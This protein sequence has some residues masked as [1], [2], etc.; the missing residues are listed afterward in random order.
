MNFWWKKLKYWVS[1]PF[2]ARRCLTFSTF[3]LLYLR[4]SGIL[5][6]KGKECSCLHPWTFDCCSGCRFWVPQCKKD[7]L[8][9]A[10]VG[11]YLALLRLTAITGDSSTAFRSRHFEVHDNFFSGK[12][13]TFWRR[14]PTMSLLKL[15]K[16]EKPRT[17][18]LS[19]LAPAVRFYET[20]DAVKIRRLM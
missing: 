6:I 15:N 7:P 16:D 20:G 13:W 8:G 18:E 4:H 1:C 11:T 17:H 5:I 12:E 14:F 3:L 9:S 2:S 19:K 10:Q